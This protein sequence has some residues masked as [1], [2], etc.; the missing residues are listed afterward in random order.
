MPIGRA[1]VRK[2]LQ[3]DDKDYHA[4]DFVKCTRTLNLDAI[5]SLLTECLTECQCELNDTIEAQYESFISLYDDISFSGK[6][7]IKGID[8]DIKQ[9]MKRVL[10]AGKACDELHEQELRKWNEL[11]NEEQECVEKNALRALQATIIC[12][13][14]SLTSLDDPERVIFFHLVLES[15][16]SKTINGKMHSI[17]IDFKEELR[18]KLEQAAV[19]L[20]YGSTEGNWQKICRIYNGLGCVNELGAL[21]YKSCIQNLVDAATD[22]CKKWLL[23]TSMIKNKLAIDDKLSCAYEICGSHNYHEIFVINSIWEPI[24]KL[25]L[26]NQEMF[27]PTHQERFHSSNTEVLGLLNFFETKLIKDQ[28]GLKLFRDLQSVK[29]L[30]DDWQYNVYFQ[31][32]FRTFATKFEKIVPEDCEVQWKPVYELCM[33]ILTDIWGDKVFLKPLLAKIFRFSLQLEGRVRNAILPKLSVPDCLNKGESCKQDLSKINQY[34]MAQVGRH[35]DEE[36]LLTQLKGTDYH[37]L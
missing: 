7:E 31:L 4:L 13:K 9:L 8:A 14:K 18:V 21:Y 5:N 32:L 22:S 16:Q 10:D 2:L 36:I 23:D 34:I 30:R 3:R 27:S 19:S 15:L 11:A 33:E 20:F 1:D 37:L 25:L 26:S 24:S 28:L 35:V 17:Y 6:D 12:F 29:K